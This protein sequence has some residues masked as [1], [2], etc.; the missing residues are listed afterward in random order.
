MLRKKCERLTLTNVKKKIEIL[1]IFALFN[2]PENKGNQWI[3]L[4][5]LS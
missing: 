1:I 4:D 5:L 3:N 2:N